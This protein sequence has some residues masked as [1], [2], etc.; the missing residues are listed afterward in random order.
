MM[1]FLAALTA[2]IPPTFRLLHGRPAFGETHLDKWFATTQF[3]NMVSPFGF[4][5]AVFLFPAAS[6]FISIGTGILCTTILKCWF[7]VQPGYPGNRHVLPPSQLY[8][9]CRISSRQPGMSQLEPW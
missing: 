6:R 5:A 1:L 7:P 3:L 9:V 8:A 2:F 4:S